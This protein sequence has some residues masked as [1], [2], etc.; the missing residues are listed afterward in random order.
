[1]SSDNQSSHQVWPASPC[2]GVCVLDEGEGLCVGCGRTIAEIGNWLK[3]DDAERAAV[4]TQLESRLEKM[5]ARP[6]AIDGM[7][8]RS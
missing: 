6:T 8:K 2:V 4:F 3:F 7:D 5:K 1:V